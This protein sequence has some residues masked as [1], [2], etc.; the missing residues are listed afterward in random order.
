[1]GSLAYL[2]ALAA[3]GA[4]RVGLDGAVALGDGAAWF[5]HHA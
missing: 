3:D 4:V 2:A 5:D 1:M